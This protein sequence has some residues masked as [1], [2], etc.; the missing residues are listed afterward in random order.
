MNDTEAER[1]THTDR[2]ALE[3]LVYH[4]L[5]VETL[6]I[7]ISRG[8]ELLGFSDMVYMRYWM[9]AYRDSGKYEAMA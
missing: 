7:S 3:W 9:K 6:C 8:R 5:M 4:A 2:E 1:I